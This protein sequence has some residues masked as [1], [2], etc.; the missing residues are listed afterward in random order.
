M[1]FSWHVGA[2]EPTDTFF[3]EE[4]D[5]RVVNLNY[6]LFVD[7]DHTHPTLRRPV[8]FGFQDRLARLPAGDQVAVVAQSG[9]QLEIVSPFTTDRD[10]T[11]ARRLAHDL[12]VTVQDPLSR[13]TASTRMRVAPREAEPNP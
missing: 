6:V 1:G 2:Q 13:E 5:V 4:V 12:V 11:R 7:D 3:G 10:A 9:R 8:L